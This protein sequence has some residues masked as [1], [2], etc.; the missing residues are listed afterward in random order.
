MAI[1][2]T[3]IVLL[4]AALASAA[5]EAI[6]FDLL[7]GFVDLAAALGEASLAATEAWADWMPP[8]GAARPGALG[9]IAV[10]VIA[11]C[12]VG[13]R[14]LR[15]RAAAAAACGAVLTWAPP[16]AVAPEPPR[17][18]FFDVARLRR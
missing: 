16:A 13:R 1:P 4:P 17:V 6:G 9:W 7:T 18:V 8:A 2:F 5:I 10:A 3:A 11:A 15:W 12:G 14:S